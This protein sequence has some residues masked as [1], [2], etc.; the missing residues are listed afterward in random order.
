[1][2]EYTAPR[3]HGDGLAVDCRD[4]NDDVCVTLETPLVEADVT[5]PHPGA[6]E[7]FAGHEDAQM[8]ALPLSLPP[9]EHSA[10]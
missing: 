5:A 10:D 3:G 9:T 6:K 2:P 1:M 4:G 8:S 7:L